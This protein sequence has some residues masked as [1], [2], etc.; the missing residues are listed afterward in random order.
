VCLYVCVLAFYLPPT[1]IMFHHFAVWKCFLSVEGVQH[2]PW[3]V[4]NILS[5]GCA[6]S[7]H[8]GR[9]CALC[10]ALSA[11]G[12]VLFG[13]SLWVLGFTMFAMWIVRDIRLFLWMLGD[14]RRILCFEGARSSGQWCHMRR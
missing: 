13:L 7:E 11:T 3:R 4:C 2:P 6:T 8:V 12:V 9:C 14:I 1:S 5:G 10:E